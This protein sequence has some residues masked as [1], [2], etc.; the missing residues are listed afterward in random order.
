MSDQLIEEREMSI[1]EYLSMFDS[2][3]VDYPLLKTRSEKLAKI[4]VKKLRD[5]GGRLL[6]DTTFIEKT[7]IQYTVRSFLD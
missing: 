7:G 5:S 1:E 6:E 3:S 2:Q 4:V